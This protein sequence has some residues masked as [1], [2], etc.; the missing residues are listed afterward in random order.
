M[1]IK[2]IKGDTYNLDVQILDANENVFD[3]TGCTVFL[4]VK[5]NLQDSDSL[6]LINKTITSHTNP[7]NGETTFSFN[8]SD[9]NYV[10]EFYYDIKIKDS[11]GLINSIFSDLFILVDH[12]TI[13]TT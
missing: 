1:I 3:L 2:R 5:R 9:V 10:G 11:N 13:R 8:A 12:V 6:A 7:T 4:T